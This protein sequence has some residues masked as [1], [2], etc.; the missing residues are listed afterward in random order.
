[1]ILLIHPLPDDEYLYTH[2]SYEADMTIDIERKVGLRWWKTE[3]RVARG[4]AS[5]EVTRKVRNPEVRREFRVVRV[6]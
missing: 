1:M 6:K 5:F 4:T 3:Q 2:I